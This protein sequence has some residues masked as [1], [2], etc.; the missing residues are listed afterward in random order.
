MDAWIIRLPE[1]PSIG[2][3]GSRPVIV[4]QVSVEGEEMESTLR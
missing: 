2:I 3:G 1:H 4:L